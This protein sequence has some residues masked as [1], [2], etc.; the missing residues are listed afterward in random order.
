MI[1]FD[2]IAFVC[3]G[4]L[5]ALGIAVLLLCRAPYKAS[6][7]LTP[8]RLLA[9]GVFFIAVIFFF[10]YYNDEFL[11]FS[12]LPRIWESL[13]S[14]V[15]HAVRLFV[16]DTDLGEF[17]A[18]VNRPLY[19][20]TA[21]ILFLIAPLLTAGVILSFFEGFASYRKCFMRRRNDAYIFS[22][23]SE[24]SLALASDLAKNHP[25]AVIIFTDVFEEEGERSFE[26]KEKAKEMGAVCF[27]KDMATLDF[28]FFSHAS[29]LYFFAI[30]EDESENITQTFALCRRSGD[31]AK[32]KNVVL[33]VFSREIENELLLS[34]LPESHIVVRRVDDDRALVHRN[35]FD[36]GEELFKHAIPTA[37]G[38]KLIRAVVVGTGGH[39]TEMLR[40]LPWF[41][42]MEGYRIEIHAFDRDASARDR[43][44]LLAP[45]LMSEKNNGVYVHGEAQYKIEFHAGISVDDASFTRE[46]AKIGT[47]TYV[48]ISMG[49]D[50]R[51]VRTAVVLRRFFRQI[52]A[53]FDPVIHAIVYDTKS[54][55]IL[56]HAKN[57]KGQE[58]GIRFIGDLEEI[59]SE[60]VIMLGDLEA[61]ALKTHLSYGADVDSFYRYEYNYR[62]SMASALHLHLRKKLGIAYFEKEELTEEERDLLERVEHNRWNAYMRAEGY[63][64]SGSPESDSRDDLALMHHNLVP[65]DELSE[66]DKRKDSIVGSRKS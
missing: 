37:D 47:P 26:L 55:G 8:S 53:P 33:Y 40:A 12:A 11:H 17:A 16:I 2:I 43:F 34:N 27:K 57:W 39:G 42:Q 60:R 6:R 52:H 25:A 59:F 21:T 32:Q 48:F 1:V 49:N 46:L 35:L 5:L 23:L 31:Y 62:S 36:S 19:S 54:K 44:T 10:P 28:S 20:V 45:E 38:K 58:Y 24:K 30:G 13:W 14:S 22:E 4:L 63:V 61:E 15:H 7:F 65:F 29:A 51:N 56:D 66:E 50:A 41:C 64:Y 3:L 18:S 9:A